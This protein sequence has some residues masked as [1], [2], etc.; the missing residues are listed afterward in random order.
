MH[1]ALPMFIE[2]ELNTVFGDGG[3]AAAAAAVAAST[4]YNKLLRYVIEKWR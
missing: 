3:D 2:C 4:F 1:T